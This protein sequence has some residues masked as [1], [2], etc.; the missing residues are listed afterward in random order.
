[1][2]RRFRFEALAGLLAAALAWPVDAATVR[3]KLG[4]LVPKGTAHHQILLRL[5]QQWA[6]V[7]ED[8]VELVL[9]TDGVAGSEAAMVQRMQI[10]Q[11]QAGLLTANG[12]RLVEPGVTGLQSVPLLFRSLDEVDHVRQVLGPELEKRLAERGFVVLFWT[13][14]GWVRFFSRQPVTGPDDLKQQKLFTWAGDPGSATI[15]RDAGFQPITLETA[16]IYTALQSGMIDAVALPT[17]YGL[18]AR[19]YR[20]APNLLML[21]YAP[22]V[23]AA[24]I[25]RQ[26]WEKVPATVRVRLLELAQEAGRAISETARR[27]SDQAVSTMVEKWGL[28]VTEPDASEMAAWRR[29]M[30]GVHPGIRGSVVPADMFDRVQEVLHE[31]RDQ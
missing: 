22:L 23:G 16:D 1:M 11:L 4:T 13:D 26:T 14:A 19:V 30:N 6:E 31:Y 21:D 2:N 27:E 3:V 24:V 18:V 20:Q 9:Y 29:V 7:S 8:Q 17:F 12:L 28:T 15:A 25:R 5:K 10:D